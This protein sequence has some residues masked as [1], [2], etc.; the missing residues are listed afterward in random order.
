MRT[1]DTNS[2]EI[3]LISIRTRYQRGGD[4]APLRPL[5]PSKLRLAKF[6]EPGDRAD[7]LDGRTHALACRSRRVTESRCI[8]SASADEPH[9]R[10]SSGRNSAHPDMSVPSSEKT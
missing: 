4:G 8:R 5:G 7:V 10:S 3:S 2:T 9:P 1:E 6:G